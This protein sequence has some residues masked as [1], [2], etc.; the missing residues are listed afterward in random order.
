[1]VLNEAW[2]KKVCKF[3]ED[4]LK[5][6]TK[7]HW[8]ENVHSTSEI[9]SERR[10]KQKNSGWKLKKKKKWSDKYIAETKRIHTCSMM[11]NNNKVIHIHF[12]LS[13]NIRCT[14]MTMCLLK[15]DYFFFFLENKRIWTTRCETTKQ[16]KKK[17]NTKFFAHFAFLLKLT[18]L[19][20]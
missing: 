11:Y 12:A 6:L 4:K 14:M 3:N 7:K 1:M 8:T 18:I 17:K 16:M 20:Q 19:N 9:R 10:T 2:N 5:L 15:N 13:A